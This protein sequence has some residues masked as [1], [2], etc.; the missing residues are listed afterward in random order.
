MPRRQALEPGRTVTARDD[1]SRYPNM[2]G[3]DKAGQAFQ[4]GRALE[5]P[6]RRQ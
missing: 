3:I 4:V 1:I 6:V 5:Q 2:R